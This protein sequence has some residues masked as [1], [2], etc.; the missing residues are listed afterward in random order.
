MGLTLIFF[1]DAW[2]YNCGENII[3]VHVCVLRSIEQR[4]MT[5]WYLRFTRVRCL[6]Y[7]RNL[8]DSGRENLAKMSRERQLT[9]ASRPNISITQPSEN[10]E[11]RAVIRRVLC[12]DT[13]LYSSYSLFRC[14]IGRRCLSFGFVWHVTCYSEMRRTKV[15]D[16]RSRQSH[17][18]PRIQY[19]CYCWVFTT[20]WLLLKKQKLEPGK[21]K[22]GHTSIC[23]P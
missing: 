10:T 1:I 2:M 11:T 8:N 5:W 16:I 9:V 14:L 12:L 6:I 3:G 4:T 22:P 23:L 19:S 15:K 18:R 7:S 21:W 17:C 20:K 13:Y